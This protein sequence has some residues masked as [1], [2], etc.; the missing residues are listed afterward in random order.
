MEYLRDRRPKLGGSCWL[1]WACDDEQR[2]LWRGS[3]Q[4]S[5][6]MRANRLL[7][8]DDNQREGLIRL[9]RSFVRGHRHD[10]IVTAQHRR[11]GSQIA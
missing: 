8:I 7:V 5:D 6:D 2:G 4:G 1:V 9:D 3:A 11:R 10:N